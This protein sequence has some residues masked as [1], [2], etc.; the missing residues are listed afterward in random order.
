M[1]M[2]LVLAISLM[3]LAL[4]LS[5]AGD[6]AGQ[7]GSQEENVAEVV[8]GF[9][10]RLTVEA[11]YGGLPVLVLWLENPTTEPFEI[12]ERSA[13]FLEVRQNDG[14][15]RAYQH[16]TMDSYRSELGPHVFEPG[17]SERE[18]ERLQKYA[19]LPPGQYTVRFSICV[20]RGMLEGYKPKSGYVWSGIVRSNSV[21]LKLPEI[22]QPPA[23]PK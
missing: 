5:V 13:W 8:N 4:S 22:T 15:W 9:R 18:A 10:V 12:T 3:A 20:D 17:H 14:S 7:A 11:G 23:T 6:G 16:P 21:V 19:E 2:R 1:G